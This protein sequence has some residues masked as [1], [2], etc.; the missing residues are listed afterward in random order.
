MTCDEAFKEFWATICKEGDP[1]HIPNK[2][3]KS[4]DA[5]WMAAQ[6]ELSRE[7][8]RELNEAAR[9]AADERTWKMVQGDDYGSY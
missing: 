4:F 7:H 2:F 8:Q 9:E 1:L 3:K 5:G 6:R